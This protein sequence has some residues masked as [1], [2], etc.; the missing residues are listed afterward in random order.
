M[1]RTWRD[2]FSVS[3]PFTHPRPLEQKR[4]SYRP[5]FSEQMC[6][7]C[8]T[9]F[10]VQWG[11]ALICTWK[12]Q[13]SIS[14]PFLYIYPHL[15]IVI[16]SLG[17]KRVLQAREIRRI[18]FSVTFRHDWSFSCGNEKCR[19]DRQQKQARRDELALYCFAVELIWFKTNVKYFLSAQEITFIF[20]TESFSY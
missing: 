1:R 4:S 3:S 16:A 18:D 12:R 20:E 13:R 19:Y 9:H 15:S 11:Q 6:A 10:S 8:R 2:Y 7:S 5:L 17:A 14:A